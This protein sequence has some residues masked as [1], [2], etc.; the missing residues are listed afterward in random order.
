MKEPNTNEGKNVTKT[1]AHVNSTY[2]SL[3]WERLYIP[4]THGQIEGRSVVI[5]LAPSISSLPL[6]VLY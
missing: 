6:A 5:S 1:V 3:L 4:L 2:Q